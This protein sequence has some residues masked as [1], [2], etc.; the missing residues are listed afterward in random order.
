MPAHIPFGRY[1]LL[2][3][4]A[5]GGM[6]ELY[7]ARSVDAPPGSRPCVLKKILPHLAESP[8]FVEMFL[9]EAKLAAQLDH[10]GI[11]RVLD[12][13]RHGADFFLAMEFLEGRDCDQ[14]LER[15][16]Q[17]KAPIPVDTAAAIVSQ[18]AEALH[19]AHERLDAQGR[20]MRVVHRDVSPS[21]L[22]IDRRAGIKVL[23]FGIAFAM[24]RLQTTHT[25]ELKGKL[26]YVSPQRLIGEPF[27]HREDIYA[28]GC[29]LSE[30]VSGAP[31][32]PGSSVQALRKAF[33]HPL[34]PLNQVRPEV[35]K[36]VER[37]AARAMEKDPGKRFNSALEL[38]LA[39]RRYL[40]S[41]PA[42]TTPQALLHRLFPELGVELAKAITVPM[43]GTME[44]GTALA[45]KVV[46]AET[47]PMSPKAQPPRSGPEEPTERVSVVAPPKR[48]PPG[49]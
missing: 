21:N 9:D 3:R 42:P 35:P 2:Q 20:P 19:Y 10:P 13:G 6:A 36:A 22:F 41:I 46:T 17:R 15:A 23:D 4:I 34:A 32:Y 44:L 25:G 5:K 24:E 8:Q 43:D 30:R 31:A 28:L 29:V 11:V 39:L 49:K 40:T 48:R 27:D 47:L 7:L 16:R 45:E 12:F 37:I 38:Q 1:Q 33:A 18:A 26:A 14:L